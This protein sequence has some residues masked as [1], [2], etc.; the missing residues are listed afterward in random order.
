MRLHSMRK[1]GERE[2]R[3]EREREKIDPYIANNISM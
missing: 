1:E 3:E 2:K